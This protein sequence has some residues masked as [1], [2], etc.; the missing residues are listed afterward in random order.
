MRFRVP[1]QEGHDLKRGPQ[2]RLQHHEMHFERMLAHERAR[3]DDNSRRP[4]EF[5]VSGG[6]DLNL[7]EGRPPFLRRMKRHAPERDAMRRANDDD[8]A[9]RLGA[10]RPRAK[11]GRGDRA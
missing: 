3:V 4:G 5:G 8:A 1:D 10:A 11:R 9:R 2:H 7:A 6:R